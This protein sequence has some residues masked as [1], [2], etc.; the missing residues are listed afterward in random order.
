MAHEDSLYNFHLFKLNYLN[1][2]FSKYT[3][4]GQGDKT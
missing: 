4:L 3:W 1:L 2:P